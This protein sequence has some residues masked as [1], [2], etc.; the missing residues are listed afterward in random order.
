MDWKAVP[1]EQREHRSGYTEE[2][3]VFFFPFFSW[4]EWK[5]AGW[6]DEEKTE[7]KEK[8]GN[9]SP[10]TASSDD[11]HQGREETAV[12]MPGGLLVFTLSILSVSASSIVFISD[13]A[14]K[15]SMTHCA[16]KC[17]EPVFAGRGGKG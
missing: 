4:S 10:R 6:K 3:W 13:T 8:Q 1:T 16:L 9:E 2:C 17:C 7:I 12:K 11:K 5:R 15:P 14:R